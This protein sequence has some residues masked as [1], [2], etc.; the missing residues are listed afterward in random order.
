MSRLKAAYQE[1]YLVTKNVYQKVLDCIDESSRRSTEDL[2]RPDEEEFEERRPSED[3]FDELAYQDIEEGVR[4]RDIP[5][6][7][8][9]QRVQEHG[10]QRVLRPMLTYEPDLPPIREVL[11]QPELVRGIPTLSKSTF[12]ER[13]YIPSRR[14]MERQSEVIRRPQTA[15]PPPRPPLRYEQV[16]EPYYS[17]QDDSYYS[18]RT[19]RYSESSQTEGSRSS[20]PLPRIVRQRPPVRVSY[21]DEGL[22]TIEDCARGISRS[23]C[24]RD[25]QL[26]TRRGGGFQCELCN[27]LLSTKHSLNRHMLKVHKS[28][29]RQSQTTTSSEFTEWDRPSSSTST[30]TAMETAALPERR[31]RGVEE[32]ETDEDIPLSKY[33]AVKQ[34]RRKRKETETEPEGSGKKDNFETWQ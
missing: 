30:S 7:E 32:Y 25:E 11:R 2:N 31:K 34:Q 20:T 12:P 23:I 5:I 18:T 27:K 16:R 24:Q 22:E 19:P 15:L 10:R 33:Q 1:M 29:S 3:Y 21:Q 26:R 8:S 14:D 6:Q 4:P 28:A 13:Y 9:D 17:E